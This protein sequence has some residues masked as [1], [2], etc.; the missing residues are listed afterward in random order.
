[1]TVQDSFDPNNQEHCKSWLE[2]QKACIWPSL[3]VCKFLVETTEQFALAHATRMATPCEWKFTG[4]YWFAGCGVIRVE[5]HT[6]SPLKWCPYCGHPIKE[7]A[8]KEEVKT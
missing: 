2:S 7:V 8:Y 6:D 4:S 5:Y 3:K 1:M